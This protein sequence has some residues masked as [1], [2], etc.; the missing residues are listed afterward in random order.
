MVG[1]GYDVHRLAEGESLILGGVRI[2][3]PI[4]TVAHSDGDV[5]LHALCDAILGAAG[6]GDIGE[7][8]PDTDTKWK[9]ADSTRFV[10]AVVEMITEQQLQLVNVDV[11]LVLES[12][13]ILP[14]KQQM[15][16]TIALLCGLPEQ[17][18]NL[19]ATTSEKLGFVGNKE[20]VQAYA[21]C[22]L[23]ELR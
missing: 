4:G 5:L 14:Y 22:Q 13:K 6:L 9:N 3:S 7:H 15:R 8:F 20:G 10:T 16:S 18:V 11:T 1:L 21:I 19:K 2:E 17:R 23:Q 12:P